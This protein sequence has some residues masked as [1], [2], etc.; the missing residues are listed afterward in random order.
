MEKLTVETMFF[1]RGTPIHDQEGKVVGFV[2]SCEGDGAG[3][4]KTQADITDADLIK[5]IK[6]GVYEI[7]K[8]VVYE[9][10]IA[11]MWVNEAWLRETLLDA[12]FN[13]S[14]DRERFP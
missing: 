3:K 7:P 12:E 14:H 6:E 5:K 9:I 13:E 8:T 10:P 2:T 1:P 4:Y 11:K